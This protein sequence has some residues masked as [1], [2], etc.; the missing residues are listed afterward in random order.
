MV[1]KCSDEMLCKYR[2]KYFLLNTY[3]TENVWI[4]QKEQSRRLIKDVAVTR[5]KGIWRKRWK[6]DE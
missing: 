6:K 3:G 4:S 1:K 2:A 5:F